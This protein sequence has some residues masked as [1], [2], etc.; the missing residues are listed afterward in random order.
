MSA[1]V[2]AKTPPEI[3]KPY[4]A[5]RTALEAGDKDLAKKHAYEAWQKAETLKGDSKITGD[6]A[7][8]YGDIGG[9]EKDKKREKALKR[10]MELARFYEA[11]SNLIWLDRSLRLT[12]YYKLS[13]QSGDMFS[14]AKDSIKFAEDNNLDKTTY[15]GEALTYKAEYYVKKA[16]H[17][18]TK[19]TTEAALAAFKSAED[20]LITVQ[21]LI[22]RLYSGFGHEGLEESMEAAL[23]YQKVME[24]IDGKLDRD[25]PLSAQVL[26]RWAY[27]RNK[28]NDEGLLDEAEEKGLCQCWPYDKPRNEALKPI[29]R[30]PPTMPRQSRRSGYSIIEFDLDD[31]GQ[32]INITALASW[33]EYYEK[34][35]IKAV[36]KWEYTARTPEETD[37]DRK[38]ILTTLRFILKD[39]GGDVIY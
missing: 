36:K 29:K 10:S 34:P 1:S 19:E 14:Q 3:I 16:N 28:L 38:D 33:P 15:Y 22:A 7:Q 30:V 21:P 5:Y 35:S 12:T 39:A 32:P 25:H 17:K 23:E 27:M 8:N 2:V 6:L 20:G 11:D 18:K 26:G 9:V 24:T 13:G 4:K 37:S 31:K